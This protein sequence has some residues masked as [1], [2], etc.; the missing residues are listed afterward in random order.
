MPQKEA[1]LREPVL[2][3]SR[4]GA[5]GIAASAEVGEGPQ[6]AGKPARSSEQ[7]RIGTRGPPTPPRCRE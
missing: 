4:K 5:R 7:M 3:P 6:K 2:H 1:E